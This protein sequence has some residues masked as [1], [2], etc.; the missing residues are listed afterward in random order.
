MR[1]KFSVQAKQWLLERLQRVIDTEGTVF[2]GVKIDDIGEQLQIKLNTL[3]CMVSNISTSDDFLQSSSMNLSGEFI[4]KLASDIDTAYA[5]LLNP[6][7][8]FLP[9]QTKPQRAFEILTER[10]TSLAESSQLEPAVIN[11]Y[12]ST[13]T[14]IEKHGTCL[15]Q[16]ASWFLKPLLCSTLGSMKASCSINNYNTVSTEALTWLTLGLNSDVASSRLKLASVYYSA[17]EW[18]TAFEVLENLEQKMNALNTVVAVC[19]CYNMR[20]KSPTLFDDYSCIRG[21]EAIKDI[22]AFCVKYHYNEMHCAPRELQYEMFRS[23]P[24]TLNVTTMTHG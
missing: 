4:L 8:L 23:T 2:L 19:G 13:L 10:R 11:D 6:K 20:M 16:A 15:E 1:K 22:I 21:D 3:Q 7:A 24:K 17:G 12:V 5:C 18:N 14:T 9:E